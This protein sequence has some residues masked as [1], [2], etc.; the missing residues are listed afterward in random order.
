ML[1]EANLKLKLAPQD[2]SMPASYPVG[3]KY[4][5]KLRT[6]DVIASESIT[7]DE[8]F[9]SDATLC[10]LKK[11]GFYRPSPIQLKAIP[12]GKCGLGL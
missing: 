8:L 1:N 12:L 5:A 4:E 11:S 9:L 6:E 10:G 3:H 7:F 2:T